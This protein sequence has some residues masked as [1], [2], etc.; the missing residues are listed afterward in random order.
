M[1]ANLL[2]IKERKRPD[3]F[4]PAAPTDFGFEVGESVDPQIV[5][6]NPRITLYCLDH[7]NKQALVC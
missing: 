1:T 7:A 4:L 2:V 5:V 3:P 6:T